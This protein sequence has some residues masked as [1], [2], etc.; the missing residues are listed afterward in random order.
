[1]PSL[2]TTLRSIVKTW[3]SAVGP[4]LSFGCCHANAYGGRA[5]AAPAFSGPRSR[6]AAVA[7]WQHAINTALARQLP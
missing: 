3:S 2:D 7:G 4:L 1:L 5:A 6:P